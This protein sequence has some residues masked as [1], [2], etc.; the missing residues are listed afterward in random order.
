M[1]KEEWKK[2]KQD[3]K[4]VIET[5]KRDL[6]LYEGIRDMIDIKIDTAKPMPNMSKE[7]KK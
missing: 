7:V 4:L 6:E 2:L 3:Y 5:T 1:Y